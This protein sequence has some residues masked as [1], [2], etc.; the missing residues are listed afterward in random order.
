[1]AQ[2][3]G[4]KNLEIVIILVD[5]KRSIGAIIPL[6]PQRFH[7]N[8]SGEKSKESENGLEVLSSV[9]GLGI[10]DAK[11]FGEDKRWQYA[12][13]W[14]YEPIVNFNTYRGWKEVNERTKTLAGF[15]FRLL[16]HLLGLMGCKNPLHRSV[17]NLYSQYLDPSLSITPKK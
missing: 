16:L 12:Y 17:L 10:G 7:K 5:K 14:M 15:G 3:E 9:E 2:I 1:L 11:K 4:T 6:S 8:I 13:A